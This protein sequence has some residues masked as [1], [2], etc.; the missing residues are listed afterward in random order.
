MKSVIVV[1]LSSNTNSALSPLNNTSQP[2]A[3]LAEINRF[4][5]G[6]RAK[7]EVVQGNPSLLR[8]LPADDLTPIAEPR[9]SA[10]LSSAVSAL[11][12]ARIVRRRQ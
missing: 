12:S 6:F 8:V 11:A 1:R 3:S 7:V 4:L 9:A 10:I 5:R 2:T